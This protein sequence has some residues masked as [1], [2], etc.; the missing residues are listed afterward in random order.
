MA[1]N[2]TMG[3]I[4]LEFLT[5]S[6]DM[7]NRFIATEIDEIVKND[8]CA[9]MFDILI[10]NALGHKCPICESTIDS[11]IGYII[12]RCHNEINSSNYDDTQKHL[13]RQQSTDFY[14]QAAQN[15]KNHF[16]SVGLLYHC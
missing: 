12:S 1:R 13:E 8:E 2:A 14:N 3:S 11:A 9:E 6:N 15:L 4:F 5:Q 16:R 7:S 10:I